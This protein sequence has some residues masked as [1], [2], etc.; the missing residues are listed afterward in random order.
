MRDIGSIFPLTEAD[1]A[2]EYILDNNARQGNKMNY[3]LCREALYAVAKKYES[4]NKVVLLP[5]YT[6]STVIDPF[7][8]LNWTCYY[9]NISE[10][11]RI[12]TED[13]ISKSKSHKPAIVVVHPYHGMEL[14]SAELRTLEIVKTYG[15]IL[16]EDITQ[17]L[18]TDNRPSIFDYFTGSYRKWFKVPDGGFVEAQNIDNL[19]TPYEQN[20]VFVM[21]QT[22]S[23]Y[24]RQKYFETDDEFIK[25]ISI[26]LNK[27]AVAGIGGKIVPHRMSD[28]SL[29]IMQDENVMSLQEKRMSNYRFLFD[30]INDNE[31]V[32]KT[33][34]DIKEVT[35][36]P[37]YFPIYAE[38]RAELKKKLAVEHIYAPILWPVYNENLL[39]NDNIKYIYSHILMLPID[40]RYDIEDM[41]KI[42]KVI[43]D[44]K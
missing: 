2:S 13:L 18:F 9:Y 42:V 27:E 25:Q 20:T 38:H 21:K 10:S 30:S 32:R 7:I 3:S 29:S 6:C 28:F 16:L 33:C 41:I 15:I 12:D 5:A 35:T 44:K 17:C 24:L 34:K 14:N 26:R 40:Q 4:T 37:L 31:A 1:F 22:D 36:A 43:T 8:Q 11:L 23:M 39:I 19:S